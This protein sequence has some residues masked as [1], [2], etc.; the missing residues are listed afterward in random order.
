MADSSTQKIRIRMKAYDYR[1][2]DQSAGEIVGA[3]LAVG[4]FVVDAPF[5]FRALGVAGGDWV[6]DVWPLLCTAAL[7]V[8]HAGQNAVADLAD[9]PSLRHRHH[10][11]PCAPCHLVGPGHPEVLDAVPHVGPRPAPLGLLVG[12]EHQVDG[13]VADGVGRD[14][15]AGAMGVED[16]GAQGVRGVLEVAA[17]P[18]GVGELLAQ[19]A[20]VPD[21]R[22]V[23]EDLGRT[24]PEPVVAQTGPD[25]EVQPDAQVV[26]GV[27]GQRVER[28][29]GDHQLHAQRE[30][31]G[32]PGGLVGRDLDRALAD[33]PAADARLRHRGQP[34]G[35][36]D[37]PGTLDRVDQLADRV[38][39]DQGVEQLLG[40]LLQQPGRPT[41]VYCAG[42]YRSSVVAS[43][44][45]SE[46]FG[47]VSDLVGGYA[48]RESLAEDVG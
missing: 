4:G 16:A 46:G 2:L 31:V 10:A 3:S 24:D 9:E 45:R 25:A 29:R 26:G 23:A 41:V 22:P 18:G 38:G 21:Q 11:E 33:P 27:P 15:P 6:D 13:G 28:V 5:E 14:P 39:E 36:V 44:L 47:D 35:E 1:L 32:V 43:M 37:A 17:L 42:G 7:V 8:T 19:G 20:G 12:V 34:L 40:L 48:A 30:A